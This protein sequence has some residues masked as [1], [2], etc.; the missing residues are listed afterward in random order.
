[1]RPKRNSIRLRLYI[2]SLFSIA[3]AVV[4][5]GAGLVLLFESHVERRLRSELNNHIRQL[6]ASLDF[7]PNGA[8]T[9][10]RAPV[11]PR[12]DRQLSGLYWQIEEER[13]Q[14][15]LRSRSLWDATLN[16]PKDKLPPG[17]V[18]RHEIKGPLM[19]D[20]LA[21]E[22]PVVFAS[23]TGPRVLRLEVAVDR[24]DVRKATEAFVNELIPSLALLALVLVGSA[25]LQINVGLRPLE[26]VRQGVN[27]I[28]SGQKERL[29]ADYPEEVTLLVHEVNELLDARDKALERARARAGDLAHGLKTP[30]TVL[31]AD[32]RKLNDRGEQEMAKEIESLALTMQRHVEH[33]L[34][35]T[36]VA[37]EARRGAA[38]A[39][40]PRIVRGIVSALRKTPWGERLEWRVHSPERL[41]A[42]VDSDDFMEVAGNLLENASKWAKSRVDASVWNVG[43]EVLLMIADDGPGAPPGMLAELCKRGT[44]LD[45]KSGGAGIGLAIAKEIV[46]AYGGR[47][48]LRN[49]AAGGLRA[50]A[51]FPAR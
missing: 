42:P 46:E 21:H 35:R 40:A 14:P 16:L 48:T 6:A 34:A 41:F 51:T 4:V 39:D 29:D 2:A 8:V 12:F 22:E 32:A 10:S 9:L 33:E 49:G 18:H 24:K 19:A 7:K 28:V 31:M 23:P 47:L 15:L 13:G 38:E 27:A 43:G 50:E 45:E 5:A 3:L 25:W 1:M 20:L 37:A 17:M 36:R 26:A 11:D 30:L 44:R